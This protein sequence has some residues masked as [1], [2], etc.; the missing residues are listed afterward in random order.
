MKK[1]ESAEN[2]IIVDMP[3]E[4]QEV[5][6]EGKEATFLRS[7]FQ[8][9]LD[10]ERKEGEPKFKIEFLYGAHRS[11]KDAEKL[12]EIFPGTDI[13]IPEWHGRSEK[14][15]KMLNEVSEGKISPEIGSELFGFRSPFF[16]KVLSIIHN[17]HAAIIL[18]DVPEDHF[19]TEESRRSVF[20]FQSKFSFKDFKADR[21]CMRNYLNKYVS[22][23]KERE[24]YM[25]ASFNPRVKEV[26]RDHPDMRKKDEIRILLSLGAFHTGLGHEFRK[27]G[28]STKSRFSR[29]PL[30]FGMEHEAMRMIRFQKEP[31]DD[32]LAK[33]LFSHLFWAAFGN[34]IL[35]GDEDTLNLTRIGREVASKFSSQDIESIYDE[36]RMRGKK[37]LKR[38]LMDK[39]AAKGITVERGK[40]KFGGKEI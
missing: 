3:K 35:G 13:Y 2:K 26:L 29:D 7:E 31:N 9:V 8:E 28:W 4:I 25:S 23:Q 24:E 39:L 27:G 22:I 6:P 32:L 10:K 40:I 20:D 34:V 14:S 5:P 12:A 18:I 15:Q 17:S 30:I 1:F 11:A 37:D 38:I 21:F 19:L 16:R 36:L 33:C